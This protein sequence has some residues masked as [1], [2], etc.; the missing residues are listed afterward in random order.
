MRR[1]VL[2]VFIVPLK[3][4]I[5]GHI[6][7]VSRRIY[8]EQRRGSVVHAEKRLPDKN[9]AVEMTDGGNL[10]K[11]NTGFPTFPPPLEIAGDFHI[12]TA[13][14]RLLSLSH[15]KH[16]NTLAPS[17]HAITSSK[18]RELNAGL[19]AEEEGQIEKATYHGFTFNVLCETD[20]GCVGTF[21]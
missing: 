11:P 4:N 2:S 7:S 21:R 8:I 18:D 5:L 10:G 15:S 19:D 9:S 6:A 14:R 12:P 17:A 3:F 1:E 13:R 16:K 20:F